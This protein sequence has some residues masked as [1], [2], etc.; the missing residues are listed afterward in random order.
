LTASAE[1]QEYL[2]WP[3]AAQVFQLERQIKRTADGK[4][5]AEVVYGITSLSPD[6]AS[7]ARLLEL[8]RSH[9][10]IENGLHY[11]R[12]ETLREDWCHLKRG[13]APHAMAVINNLIVGLVLHLGWTNLPEARRYLDAH[14]AEA[15]RI[16]MRQLA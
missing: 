12:D 13:Q 16:V 11:R 3:S 4:T 10:G 15:R 9:W 14:P 1:L 8:N 5:S 6:R 2:D 7:P